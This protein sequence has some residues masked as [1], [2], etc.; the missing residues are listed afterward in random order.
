MSN[1]LH[2]TV[3]PEGLA[4][5]TFDLPGK[6]ANIFNR[7]VIAELEELIPS[8]ATDD[9]IR[10]LI[11]RSGKP[12][13]FIAGADVEEI[14]DVTDP[15]EAEAGSRA[16]HRLFSAW[17]RLPFPTIAAVDGTC[18]GGGTELALASTWIVISDSP[19]AKMGL[20]EVRLGILPG[21]G[22]CTRLP[23]RV[24]VASALDMILTGRNIVGRKAFKMGL[25]D[26]LMPSV[27][28]DR[29]LVAFAQAK[30]GNRHKPSRP[31][32]LRS[33]L[34]EKNP[35]G[36]KIVFDQA[37]KQTLSK[38]GGHYPA[39]LRAI[40]VVRT[41]VEKGSEAGFDA[42]ARA[43]GELAVSPTAK[44]LIHLFG[45]M[46]AA[47]KDPEIEG[48]EIVTIREAAALGAG[49]MGG[50]IAQLLADKL[51]VPV[52]MKDI[53]EPA[54]AS[55]M[56]HAAGLFHQ[57]VKRRRLKRPEGD[58]RLA[59]IRPTLDFDGFGRA[60]VVIEAV[61]ENLEIK[62]KVFAETAK[63]VRE[64]TILASNTSSLSIDAIGALTPHP[65]RVIGMHFFNP[66]HKMPL[67]EIVVGSNTGPTAIRTIFDLTRRLGKTPVIVR[68]GPGFLV[69][70]LLM[71]YSSEAMWLLDEGFKMEDLDQ[72][73]TRWGMPVGPI[74][75]TDEVG[76][77][78]AVKVAHILADAFTE[79]LPL[80]AWMDG[81]TADKRLGRKSGS[82]F[83]V[84]AKGKRK[85]PDPKAYELL[86]LQ[87]RVD[88]PELGALAR[89]MVLPMVNEAAR[90][91]DEGIVATPGELDLAMIMGTGFPPFRGG[92][93][94]WADAQGLGQLAQE[95]ER[96]AER[97]G[98]R[99][100]PSQALREK[101]EAGGF[102]A[103]AAQ[104]KEREPQPAGA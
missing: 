38:T 40:E 3:D 32:G 9:R 4:T 86:G 78:V 90:C 97:L 10:C 1:A 8:L 50:G 98:D 2:L 6:K 101:A 76:I 17:E 25:A 45:L 79:R 41:G 49:V 77:D 63:H 21:W 100:L 56:A 62:Q 51:D 22:G 46:E 18:L 37:R 48:G 33:L 69:N 64:D 104:E 91:L 43:I 53:A 84:Y 66:V 19:K 87:P 35:L 74:T 30:A 36:R 39:A 52:R 55:G 29:H 70:R 15:T 47:K 12:G 75:L 16:G 24:G 23:K 11:L 72:A 27:G 58:R 81:L 102:Y 28:L 89:R 13:M 34:L 92:L 80:P 61:V 5:L 82:G 93:C 65:E 42:E 94:R 7:Q 20:P 14:R 59:L 88:D 95:M 31:S 73:M 44:N 67:V 99:F 85:G 83:Y 54:L 60:D 68:E 96:W 103:A 71:F 26:A 57:Q